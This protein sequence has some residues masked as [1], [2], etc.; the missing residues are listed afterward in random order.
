[1]N[2]LEKQMEAIVEDQAKVMSHHIEPLEERVKS[3]EPIFKRL[4][5]IEL[6]LKR[7]KS[8]ETIL[9]RLRVLESLAKQQAATLLLLSESQSRVIH[10]Q[11]V[12]TL[13][14]EKMNKRMFDGRN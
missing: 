11:A 7:L 8:I 4:E 5:N 9:K 12:S 1:M 6:I 2:T 10:A 3:I 13:I 14:V